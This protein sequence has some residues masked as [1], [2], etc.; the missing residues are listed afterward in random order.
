MSEIGIAP[1]R[2]RTKPTDKRWLD[3]ADL[4]AD[5][6]S[7]FDFWL[8]QRMILANN[9]L[10]LVAGGAKYGAAGSFMVW[11]TL[12]V[13]AAIWAYLLD[14]GQT[15][16]CGLVEAV[17]ALAGTKFARLFVDEL[18]AALGA[19]THRVF[20]FALAVAV[21]IRASVTAKKALL[22]REFDLKLFA[23]VGANSEECGM[24]CHSNSPFVTLLTPRD[25]STHRRGN[26]LS[27]S[28]IP[29]MEGYCN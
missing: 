1:L 8:M 17:R 10:G 23:A 9:S 24:I 6:A 26:Y 15:T 2:A 18:F 22:V 11:R 25:D 29:Q 19:Y 28:I 21:L 14:A 13:F 27:A 12:K 3:L 7:H 5:R 20:T 16:P 4:A